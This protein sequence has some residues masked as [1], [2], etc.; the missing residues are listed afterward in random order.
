M[1][2]PLAPSRRLGPIEAY[3]AGGF[4]IGG[5][6]FT[7]SIL[8]LPEAVLPWASPRASPGAS[9]DLSRLSPAALA[10]VLE[11][12]PLVEILLLGCGRRM[13]PISPELRQAL[14]ESGVVIDAMDTGAACRTYNVLAA[15][16]RL[17]AALLIAVD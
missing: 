15:E 5:R 11:A 8:L 17:V 2:P 14:R 13:A 9:E 3:G 16:G 12:R 7:G 4:R 6:H 1:V 10:P